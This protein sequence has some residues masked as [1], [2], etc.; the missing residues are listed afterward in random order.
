MFEV[1]VVDDLLALVPVDV[2]RGSRAV[3]HSAL[4]NQNSIL[5]Y[6]QPKRSQYLPA[7]SPD[8]PHGCRD[9]LSPQ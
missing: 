3:H 5:R 6:D 4:S 8:C 1:G 7:A 2:G 9:L